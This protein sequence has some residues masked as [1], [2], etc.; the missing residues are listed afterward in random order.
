MPG[1]TDADYE[2]WVD[3]M[4]ASKFEYVVA[5]QTYGRNSRSKDLRLR[6]LAQGV[7]T[8]VQR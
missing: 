6:Q 2:R 5:V 7:D 3:N 1:I 8:L 4:V